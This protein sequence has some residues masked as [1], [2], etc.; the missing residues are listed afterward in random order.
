MN[1]KTA[2]QKL[3]EKGILLVD[4]ISSSTYDAVISCINEYASEVAREKSEDLL[5]CKELYVELQNLSKA[6]IEDL[7]L[8][9]RSKVQEAVKLARVGFLYAE[10]LKAL[11]EQEIMDKLNLNTVKSSEV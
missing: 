3:T 5:A 2:K 8:N 6:K 4:F 11:S 1:M 7:T 9:L 10:G